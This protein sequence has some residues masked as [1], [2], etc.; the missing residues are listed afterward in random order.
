MQA[1]GIDA[2]AFDATRIKARGIELY[3]LP[4]DNLY[5]ITVVLIQPRP[6]V[7]LDEL[8]MT[9]QD[10]QVEARGIE[11]RKTYSLGALNGAHGVQT[12]TITIELSDIRKGELIGWEFWPERAEAISARM[13]VTI[14]GLEVRPMRC[15]TQVVNDDGAMAVVSDLPRMYSRL[16][17]IRDTKIPPYGEFGERRAP[18]HGPDAAELKKLLSKERS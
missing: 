14:E 15:V 7:R 8:V 2:R 18:A 4:E 6:S 9:R 17:P 3:R 10:A 13:G 12:F 5:Q 1:A 16:E 11:K